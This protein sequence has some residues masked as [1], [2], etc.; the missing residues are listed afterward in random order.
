MLSVRPLPHL[1]LILNVVVKPHKI[2]KREGLNILR[3]V[4]VD[5][6]DAILGT[7][8]VVET[9]RGKTIHV[10]V[11]ECTQDNDRLVVAGEGVRTR[12][13]SGDFLLLIKLKSPSHISE[14]QRR[15]LLEF[16]N[17]SSKMGRA[18]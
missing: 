16:Q 4:G 3:A 5:S 12:K 1:E 7:T 2:F 11:P 18:A 14:R 9:V 8:V 13:R 10:T 17:E 6:V 15:L